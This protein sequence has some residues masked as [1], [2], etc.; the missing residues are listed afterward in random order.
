MNRR[1]LVTR[2]SR[3]L[4]PVSLL[5]RRHEAER[6]QQCVL[7]G[8]NCMVSL[9]APLAF[10]MTRIWYYCR[11]RAPASST[12]K[13]AVC[14]LGACDSVRVPS[15]SLRRIFAPNWV[16]VPCSVALT[17]C[18][19]RANA[20]AAFASPGTCCPDALCSSLAQKNYSARNTVVC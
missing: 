15:T 2:A 16:S 14:S 5:F 13:T 18:V 3:T 11:H 6:Y 1:R 10:P 4:A 20:H 19:P 7:L 8:M 9:R 12:Q 17:K